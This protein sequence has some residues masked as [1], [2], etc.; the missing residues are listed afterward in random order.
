M[1]DLIYVG[2]DVAQDWLDVF[3]H[4]LRKYK[5]F[6]N[7][8]QGISKLLEY[9]AEQDGEIAKVVLDHFHNLRTA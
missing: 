2:I 4:P 3:L 9:L 8:T 6:P 1:T 7:T 5:R